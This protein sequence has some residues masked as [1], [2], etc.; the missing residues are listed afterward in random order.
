MKYY[1]E[2]SIEQKNPDREAPSESHIP[3][4]LSTNHVNDPDVHSCIYHCGA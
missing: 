4:H 3:G 1:Q 2:L